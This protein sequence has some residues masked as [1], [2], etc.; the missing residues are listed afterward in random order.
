MKETIAAAVSPAGNALSLDN[1]PVQGS[2]ELPSW[3]RVSDL[4]QYVIQAVANALKQYCELSGFEIGEL[5]VDRNLAS[6]WFRC[7][8]KPTGWQLPPTW[9]EI[10]GYYQTRD[11]GW[12]QLHTNAP[13]HCAA[14]LAVLDA[15]KQ[16]QAVADSVR[17]WQSQTLEN[18]IVAAGGCAATLRSSS[19]WLSHPQGRAVSQSPLVEWEYRAES[20]IDEPLLPGGAPFTGIR[21]L[22]LTRIIA[23]PVATRTLAAFGADVLRLDPP[24]WHEDGNLVEMTIGKRCAGIDLKTPKGQQKLRSL[25]QDADVLVHGYRPGALQVLG[26]GSDALL[27]INP[28]LIEVSLCAWGWQGPFAGRRGFDSLVQTGSGIAWHGMRR[29][30][31]SKPEPLPVQALDHATGYLMAACAINALTARRLTGQVCRARLSLA[32]TGHLLQQWPCEKAALPFED[33]GDERYRKLPETTCWGQLKR[34][35]FPLLA[36]GYHIDWAHAAGELRSDVAEWG[37]APLARV[38]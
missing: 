1:I 11:G 38:H 27:E 8:V 29:S 34:L 31:A 21:V 32:A 18:E 33:A 2:A 5:S 20:D 7:S 30:G 25:V 16:R 3:Y 13:H 6:H 24:E 37:L 4:A 26:F 10:A 9:D 12:I 35:E 17:Q 28:G 14:A 19:E 15:P 36:S 23:G 22:D